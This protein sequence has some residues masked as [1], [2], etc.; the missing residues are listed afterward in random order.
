MESREDKVTPQHHTV[1]TNTNDVPKIDT[2]LTINEYNGHEGESWNHYYR[3]PSDPD[4]VDLLNKFCETVTRSGDGRLE[5]WV[6]KF[7]ENEKEVL[8]SHGTTSYMN[9]H[10]FW[11]DDELAETLTKEV[12]IKIINCKG[13]KYEYATDKRVY[14]G[15]NVKELRCNC[16]H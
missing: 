3:V 1:G 10:N 14:E 11:D 5:F 16:K 15:V 8:E 9:T 2:Y 13:C 7:T 6:D 4:Y 12:L